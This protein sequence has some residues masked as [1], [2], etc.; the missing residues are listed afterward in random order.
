MASLDCL[1]RLD[2]Q[3]Q[4]RISRHEL[5]AV[6]D[7]ARR[8]SVPRSIV[9]RAAIRAVVNDP[10]LVWSG[11]LLEPADDDEPAAASPAPRPAGYPAKRAR[12][13][14]RKR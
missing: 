12:N 13:R 11:P 5:R 10:T 1:P 8:L 3:L 4:L 7:V 14:K 2:Q 9:V 6:N